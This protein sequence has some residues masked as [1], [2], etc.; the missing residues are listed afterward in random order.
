MQNTIKEAEKLIK[1]FH[2]NVN[3]L[4]DCLHDEMQWFKLFTE[5]TR[6]GVIRAL[7]LGK[8]NGQ[9]YHFSPA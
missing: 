2:V 7:M 4:R 5:E 6:I 8:R 9:P 3:L 1:C